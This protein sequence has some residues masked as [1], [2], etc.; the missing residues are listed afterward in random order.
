MAEQKFGAESGK[1]FGYTAQTFAIPTKDWYIKTL[2]IERI[3]FYIDRFLA[4]A[5]TRPDFK[6]YVTAIATGLAG[7]K[8][9]QIAPL[10]RG[11]VNMQNVY[12]PL[13]FW[14]ILDKP[15]KKYDQISMDY[16]N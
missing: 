3:H 11:A 10:F 13:E 6:F 7:Y 14:E 15:L 16:D 4:F 5:E 8:P 12:L 9:E 1:G 2:D